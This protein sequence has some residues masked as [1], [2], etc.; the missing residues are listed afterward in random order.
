MV[1]LSWTY[2]FQII[3]FIVLILLLKKYLFKPVKAYLDK[4]AKYIEDTM[5]SIEKEK[6]ET[7]RIKAYNEGL[8]NEAKKEA[9]AI[10]ERAIRQGEDIRDEI[11]AKAREE[12]E[13]LITKANEEIEREKEKAL[14]QLRNEI[15][16]ISILAAE[17]VV[18]RTITKEDNDKM[19]AEFIEEVGKMP[20]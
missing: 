3:N 6:E 4:R 19:V 8:I 10:T 12:A 11:V 9:Q 20:C 15:A 7:A 5:T 14:A 2:F 13:K 18:G 16:S 1:E 17:K